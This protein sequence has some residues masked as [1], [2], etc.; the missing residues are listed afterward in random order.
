MGR[1]R[2]RNTRFEATEHSATLR[3]VRKRGTTLVTKHRIRLIAKQ[4][5][6]D[7]I[8]GLLLFIS[9]II[10]LL[11]RLFLKTNKQRLFF[12]SLRKTYSLKEKKISIV[13]TLL[14]KQVLKTYLSLN[15][16]IESQRM[17]II[18]N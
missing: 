9:N 15:N 5:Y 17:I 2:I 13:Y 8:K 12:Q 7:I 3:V 10:H 11:G 14:R 4:P 16:H 18:N 1:I 6:V